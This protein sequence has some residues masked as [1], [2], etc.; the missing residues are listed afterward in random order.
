MITRQSYSHDACPAFSF[1][2]GLAAAGTNVFKK[3][4]VLG[5]G[6]GLPSQ[7]HTFGF[8]VEASY[9]HR[10]NLDYLLFIKNICTPISPELRDLR[11]IGLKARRGAAFKL[12][13]VFKK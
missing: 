4:A 1:V 11:E 13:Q 12:P 6:F 2:E 7:F 5:S 10:L 3:S 9:C 8:K